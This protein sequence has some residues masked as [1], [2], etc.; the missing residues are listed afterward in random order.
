MSIENDTLLD[1]V[2]KDGQLFKRV[3]RNG[4]EVLEPVQEDNNEPSRS[5]S[6][7]FDDTETIP[8]DWTPP[9]DNTEILKPI[10]KKG[11]TRAEHVDRSLKVEAV[12]VKAFSP[13]M[14]LGRST[15]T[16]DTNGNGALK[17]LLIDLCKAM[18]PPWN[19]KIPHIK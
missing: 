15:E 8:Q 11:M 13:R 2:I 9:S 12:L 14:R 19:E 1:I 7:R 17:E 3:F 5:F 4:E 6:Q 18:G 16:I 10:E